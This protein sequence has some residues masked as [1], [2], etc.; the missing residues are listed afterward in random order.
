MGEWHLGDVVYDARQRQS[1]SARQLSATI[2]K[3]ESYV[4]KLERGDLQPG[5]RT[6]CKIAVALRFTPLE[7]V[8]CVRNEARCD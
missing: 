1:M 8:V 3:S 7:I 5:L 2:G 6:F 4:T